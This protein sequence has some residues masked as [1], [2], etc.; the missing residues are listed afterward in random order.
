M[1]SSLRKV[2]PRRTHRERAQPAARAKLGL[3]EKHKDYV[4]RARNFHSKEK[5]IL[6][7]Q[8]KARLRNPDEF[9]HA[10]EKSK[11][12]DG[13]HIVERNEKFSADFLK[14]LKTQDK[15]YVAN[16]RNVNVKKIEKLQSELHL[17]GASEM[18]PSRPADDGETSGDDGEDSDPISSI[19]M[20]SRATHTI[21]VDTEEDATS[22]D[23]SVHFDTPEQFLARRFNRPTKEMLATAAL[24]NV[25]RDLNPAVIKN[26]ERERAA[27]YAELASRI[28][29]DKKLRE[30]ELEMETQKALM[31]KGRR[32]KVG[33]DARGLSVYKWKPERKT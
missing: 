19:P 13:V 6:S 4:L 29:R 14:L 12:K 18:L 24:P 31:G 7:M 30:A 23:P 17:L 16:Q 11:T 26:A 21:F 3:L 25:A 5:R 2:A 33:V 9:Y 27:K 20:V 8:K 32:K 28:A 22:F 15:G 1:S 10:M